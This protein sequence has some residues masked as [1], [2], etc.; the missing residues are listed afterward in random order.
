LTNNYTDP[1]LAAPLENTTLFLSSLWDYP[2]SQNT[3]YL[4]TFGTD[5][6]L[7][8]TPGWDNVTGVGTPNGKAFV[9]A[10]KNPPPK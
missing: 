6:G 2:L 10:F 3:T 9:D 8:V 4:L 5:T 1:Q 7:T